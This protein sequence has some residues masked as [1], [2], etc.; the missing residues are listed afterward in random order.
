MKIGNKFIVPSG[1][2]NQA[3]HEAFFMDH[4]VYILESLV[5]GTFYKG[6]SALIMRIGLSST[7]QV[8]ASTLRKKSHGD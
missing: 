3:S 2:P 5:D 4:Y 7:T 6:Y 1:P 8:C